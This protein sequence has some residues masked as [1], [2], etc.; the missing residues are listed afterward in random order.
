[1]ETKVCKECKIK[2]DIEKFSRAYSKEN[3]SNLRRTTCKNCRHLYTTKYRKDNREILQ[4]KDKLKYWNRSEEDK[5]QFIKKKSLQNQRKLKTD[6]KEAER[7]KLYNLSD[8]GIFNRYKND[9]K[10][11]NRNYDFDLTF[12]H[13][14]KLINSN[15]TYCNSFKCRGVDRIE[16]SKG[17]TLEN[18]TPCCKKCN[19]MKMASSI[20]EFKIQILKIYKHF[21]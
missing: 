12:E 18:A 8:R 13:F 6:P 17:Y 11:R 7:R 9:A 5:K 14:S 21:L 10:R 20:E 3:P 19:E 1:M 16:N 15:C 4:K 2:K